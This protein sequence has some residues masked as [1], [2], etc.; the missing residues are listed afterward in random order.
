MVM[1]S[2][3]GQVHAMLEG[4]FLMA[5]SSMATRQPGM[6]MMN[7]PYCIACN[8]RE[9][10][11]AIANVAKW[12]E[13]DTSS[14]SGIYIGGEIGVEG[15][16]AIRRAVEHLA[17]IEIDICSNRGAMVVEAE[18]HLETIWAKA[19]S[20]GWWIKFSKDDDGERGG[21]EEEGD[22]RCHRHD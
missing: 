2:E 13:V 10:A 1:L 5:L 11:E 19:S 6:E 4:P 20:G 22:K 17:Q 12:V 7:L 15:W 18:D 8:S 16:E 14:G 9:G 21:W 3:V